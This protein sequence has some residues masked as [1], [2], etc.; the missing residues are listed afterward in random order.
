MP[1]RLCSFESALSEPQILWVGE[2]VWLAVSEGSGFPAGNT[3]LQH[4]RMVAF[5]KKGDLC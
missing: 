5:P 1:A 3:V 4:F 2:K